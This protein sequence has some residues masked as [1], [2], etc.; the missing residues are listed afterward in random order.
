MEKWHAG[1]KSILYR[2]AEILQFLHFILSPSRRRTV[3]KQTSQMADILNPVGVTTR[4]DS[5][6]QLVLD[7]QVMFTMAESPLTTSTECCIYKIPANIRKVNEE[8][9]TPK[10]ISIGPFHFGNERFQYMERFKLRYFR[11]FI[12]RANQI[13]LKSWVAYIKELEPR[14]RTCYTNILELD[15]DQLVKV[16]LVDA[17]FI[18]ELFWRCHF[19]D[20]W[21]DEDSVL[22]K[23]WLLTAIRIDLL[24]L[25]NQ[26]PFFVLEKIFERAFVSNQNSDFPSLLKFT[27]GYFAYYNKIGLD[28]IANGGMEIKHFTDLLRKFHLLQMDKLPDRADRVKEIHQHTV[29]GLVGAGLKCKVASSIC[30]L[31]LKFS[32]KVLEIPQFE[33]DNN[34]ETLFRNLLALEQCHYPYQSYIIDY[35]GMMDFLIN[36]AQDVEI[37]VRKGIMVN[38]LGD[39][40]AAANLFNNLLENITQ[41]NYNENYLR[42]CDELNA[43]CNSPINKGIATL[44][45]DYCNTTWKILASVAA[46]FLLLLTVLQTIFSGISAI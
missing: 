14:V 43:F 24:L 31:D 2:V 12:E 10:V 19:G 7:V 5:E 23:P 39:D 44:K 9:Y 8:A 16:I 13:D 11:S 29:T 42:L 30:L 38:W 17:T 1:S 20:C 18:L 40:D 21:T 6:S 4:V 45:R 25:E 3:G 33:V 15:R 41:V 37:L 26:L 27:F 22:L 34:T 32:N 35:I 46:I 36:T 28:P